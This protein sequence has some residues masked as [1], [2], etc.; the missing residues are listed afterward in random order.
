MLKKRNGELVSCAGLMTWKHWNEQRLSIL[1]SSLEELEL[2]V[3]KIYYISE[4]SGSICWKFLCLEPKI[5]IEEIQD[6]ALKYVFSNKVLLIQLI[7]RP[8]FALE[9]PSFI[10][11][12]QR[13]WTATQGMR[14]PGPV[15]FL[16]KEPWEVHFHASQMKEEYQ[17]LLSEWD[18]PRCKVLWCW[19]QGR[20][21]TGKDREKGHSRKKQKF[22]QRHSIDVQSIGFGI[23]LNW[24]HTPALPA[25]RAVSMALTAFHITA[26]PLFFIS[27]IIMLILL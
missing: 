26:N 10:W 1:V 7:P 9:R 23:R 16:A 8:H 3:L 14:T 15:R 27:Y 20:V 21:F 13:M 19:R 6:R 12:S 24:V 25:I 4:L 22:E 17:L 18:S 5:L 11:A 2:L